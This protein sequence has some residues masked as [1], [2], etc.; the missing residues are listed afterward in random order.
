MDE[1]VAPMGSQFDDT[2]TVETSTASSNQSY[3]HR[4]KEYFFPEETKD[5]STS[6]SKGNSYWNWM[7]SWLGYSSPSQDSL[8][9]RETYPDALTEDEDFEDSTEEE[10][11][12]SG[13]LWSWFKRPSSPEC[14]PEEQ[15]EHHFNVCAKQLNNNCDIT[16]LLHS[17]AQ[18][19]EQFP[20]HASRTMILFD[21]LGNQLVDTA[22][23]VIWGSFIEDQPSEDLIEFL[24]SNDA[25]LAYAETFPAIKDTPSYTDL[26]RLIRGQF[27]DWYTAI[28]YVGGLDTE[29]SF[30]IMH[31]LQ[32]TF[33]SP[34]MKRLI[35]S[36]IKIYTQLFPDMFPA[37]R[38]L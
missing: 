26:D 38:T 31:D 34:Q 29:L 21:Q 3:W 9:E 20:Q 27:D 8:V 36:V 14:N 18:L 30:Q 24:Y 16:V 37:A 13:S 25:F 15:F 28:S 4:F 33:R 1:P 10:S 7:R 12:S 35:T 17:L 22:K 5:D 6:T 19:L 32:R 11:S 2:P 23:D